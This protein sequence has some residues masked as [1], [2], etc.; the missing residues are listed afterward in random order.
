MWPAGVNKHVPNCMG[1]KAQS[2]TFGDFIL[3]KV[4]FSIQNETQ[5]IIHV[6]VL[7]IYTHGVYIYIHIYIYCV[8]IYIHTYIYIVYI[9]VLMCKY[10]YIYI[11]TYVYI[12][13]YVNICIYMY[14]NRC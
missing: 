11:S 14:I 2:P 10:K 9:Y 4:T 6:N 5:N 12:S 8:Y 7:Y 3:V 1:W 13:I